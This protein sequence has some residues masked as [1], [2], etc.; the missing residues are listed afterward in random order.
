MDS[1]KKEYFMYG[2]HIV[3]TICDYGLT[4]MYLNEAL[5]DID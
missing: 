4:V 3:I 1:F 5:T 2:L